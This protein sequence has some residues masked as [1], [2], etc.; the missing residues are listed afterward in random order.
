MQVRKK[1]GKI[2][3]MRFASE[4]SR[5]VVTEALRYQ[6]RFAADQNVHRMV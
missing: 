6:T 1:G 2:D 5:E 4:F 3:T